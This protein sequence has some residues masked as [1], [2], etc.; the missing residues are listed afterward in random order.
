MLMVVT[1]IVIDSVAPLGGNKKKRTVENISW[2]TAEAERLK[3]MWKT[4]L[5]F[6]V[7]FLA[8]PRGLQDLGSWTR[9]RTCAAC[10]GGAES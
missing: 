6:F 4:G 9:D 10:S 3:Q 7:F 2:Y 5:V 1:T 8:S